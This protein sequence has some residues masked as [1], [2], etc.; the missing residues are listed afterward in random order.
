MVNVLRWGCLV[1]EAEWPWETHLPHPDIGT[2]ALYPAPGHKHNGWRG[3]LLDDF[4]RLNGLIVGLLDG[5]AG[6][7]TCFIVIFDCYLITFVEHMFC[8]M[9][10]IILIVGGIRNHF[11]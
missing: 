10:G 6:V 11:F 3:A 9:F 5:S 4:H 8:P 1:G 2:L 7:D